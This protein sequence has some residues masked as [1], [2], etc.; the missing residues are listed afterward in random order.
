MSFLVNTLVLPIYDAIKQEYGLNRGEYVLLMCLA[1]YDELTAQD[2]VNMS[3]RPRN[4]ISRS[5]HRMLEE[6]YLSR[7][8]HPED[9]RQVWL[10][11]TDEGL[12]LHQEL[13]ARFVEREREFLGIL[14]EEE[15]ESLDLILSKLADHAVKS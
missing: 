1:H 12:A 2:V 3:R 11:I 13:M 9:R 4:S 10:R 14:S 7:S 6:G 5:V 15:Q 8:P